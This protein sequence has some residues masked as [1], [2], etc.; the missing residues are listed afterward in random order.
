MVREGQAGRISP[1]VPG[2][3]LPYYEG[4]QI[5]P[6]QTESTAAST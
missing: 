1:E 5:G 2:Q 3:S 6:D 4:A